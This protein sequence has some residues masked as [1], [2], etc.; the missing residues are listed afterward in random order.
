MGIALFNI[1]MWI[2][3]I[4]MFDLFIKHLIYKYQ[5][6]IDQF[7]KIKELLDIERPVD[8]RRQVV[9]D[10]LKKTWFS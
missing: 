9:I 1:E 4:L 6:Y 8:K 7:I 3:G 10:S 2:V 5:D